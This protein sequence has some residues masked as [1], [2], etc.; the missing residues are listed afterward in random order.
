MNRI[1]T[2]ARNPWVLILLL[3]VGVFTFWGG[4]VF[5][6]S[7]LNH[8]GRLV[9]S[10]AIIPVAVAVVLIWRRMWSTA[11]WVYLTFGLALI[12][13]VLTMGVYLWVIPRG[14]R[15]E[16]RP[17]S[18][19]APP[20]LVHG[21]EGM[22]MEAHGRIAGTIGGGDFGGIAIAALQNIQAGKPTFRRT[23]MVAVEESEVR[24]PVL[25]ATAGDSIRPVNC[26]PIHHSFLLHDSSQQ[27]FQLPL[28]P[29]E[30]TTE[31]ALP[32]P[33]S[34]VSRCVHGHPDERLYVVVFNHPYHRRVSQNGGFEF[35]SVP[36]GEH[37]VAIWIARDSPDPLP[38]KPDT[39]VAVT[40][41]PH[42]AS[43]VEITMSYET[44]GAE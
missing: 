25:T 30:I 1:W 26:D 4:P 11:N 44:G 5:T 13:M 23:H 8:G 7:S 22:E 32:S 37:Q 17:I 10:Y 20:A 16:S 42:E 39:S 2:Y 40:V 18:H 36:P 12:K 34:F 28:L 19:T 35:D 33:G 3:S 41:K 38:A 24:P 9:V 14:A 43:L 29:A 21:Y 31:R 15:L 6:A 27:L